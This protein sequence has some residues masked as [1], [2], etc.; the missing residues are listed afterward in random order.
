MELGANGAKI[1]FANGYTLTNLLNPAVNKRQD[2]FGG[3]IEKRYSYF[4]KVIDAL[5]AKFG[6][7]KIGVRISP[8][9]RDA[10]EYLDSD[11]VANYAYFV[12][13][14]ENRR[15]DFKVRNWL[16]SI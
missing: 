12:S 1:H 11:I 3:S 4:L 9:H 5:G 14:L 6:Y 16:I 10:N 7:E 13:Q 15:E 2:Q 8:F